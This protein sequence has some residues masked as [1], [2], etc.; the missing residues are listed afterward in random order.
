MAPLLNH[1]GQP[2]GPAVSGWMPPPRPSREMMRGRYCCITP[3]SSKHHAAELFKAN[4]ADAE[5]RMW[6]YLPYGPFDT[7]NDYRAWIDKVCQKEDPLFYAVIDSNT[8]QAAGVASFLRIDPPNGTIEV[9]HIAYSPPMQRTRAATEAMF[10][11]MQQVF[12]LGYRRYEWKCDA[13]NENSRR[14]AER[15]GFAFEGIFRQ[16]IIYKGRSRDTAWYSILDRDWPALQAAY[17]QWLDPEN[18]DSKGQQKTSLRNLTAGI[19][20]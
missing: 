3:L 10:L 4:Q 14:A 15:L 8:G 20:N 7:L 5:G 12:T 2:I 1:L 18:F 19:G 11:M 6:T 16:A 9:G 13:L 17:R